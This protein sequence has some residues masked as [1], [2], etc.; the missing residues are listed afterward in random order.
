[1]KAWSTNTFLLFAA[2]C[3]LAWLYAQFY[4]IECKGLSLEEMDAKM[5]GKA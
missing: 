5:A 3:L 2:A 4:V 1:M